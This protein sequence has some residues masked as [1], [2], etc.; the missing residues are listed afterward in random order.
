MRK[1]LAVVLGL[2]LLALP[3]RA[4]ARETVTTHRLAG[5]DRIGTAVVAA[6]QGQAEVRRIVVVAL[7]APDALPASSLG[8]P[9]LLSTAAELPQ[10][11]RSAIDELVRRGATEAIVVG[12]TAVLSAAVE[13]E[14]ASRVPTRRLGGIDRAGTAEAVADEL[15]R[16]GLGTLDGQP[17]A[18]VV[19]WDAAADAVTGGGLA[20]ARRFPLFL[21]GGARTAA[22][23]DRL[24]VRRVLAI[25]GPAALPEDD[26]A[27]LSAAD[28]PVERIAGSDRFATA[29][30]V[31]VVAV[32]RLRLSAA[33]IM[34]VNGERQDDGVV[35]AALAGARQ[36]PM[37][38]VR[39]SEL[40]ERSR[41][42]LDGYAT[43]IEG[44]LVV[45]GLYAVNP[46]VVD[47]AVT[48]S[49]TASND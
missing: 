40:P 35:A 28:R 4:G 16:T 25:G 1:V 14:L 2:A 41:A 20:G 18:I 22:A 47:Q 24:G 45:G 49:Q 33:K 10:D 42:A 34:L 6:L 15:A 23:L 38:L 26:L 37:A 3:G 44:L 11:V 31:L 7:G 43:V 32:E 19:G 13:A 36:T 5:Q 21:G 17:T 46:H 12:G 27:A 8:S 39:A 48:A 30:D 9:I 29:A